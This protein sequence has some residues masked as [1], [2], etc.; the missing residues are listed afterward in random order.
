MSL[1]ARAFKD[2]FP[3]VSIT[4]FQS[5]AKSRST[6][7]FKCA[8]DAV[9]LASNHDVIVEDVAI[10]LR[11]HVCQ[12]VNPQSN[13][14]VQETQRRACL[15]VKRNYRGERQAHTSALASREY[16]QCYWRRG[17]CHV[18]RRFAP[19]YT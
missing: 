1:R 19:L 5:D 4:C 9:W 18:L 14:C 6:R 12:P 17:R 11:N 10:Q 16:K 15:R 3:H 2:E 7:F 13:P 8:C